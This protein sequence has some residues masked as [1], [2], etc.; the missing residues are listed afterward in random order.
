M[1][2]SAKV[3]LG[4]SIG[5][6]ALTLILLIIYVPLII[7][8]A[9]FQ[10]TFNYE[11]ERRYNDY[12]NDDYYDDDYWDEDYWDEDFLEQFESDRKSG[13]T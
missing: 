3:G 13:N 1:N 7:Y 12:Y 2:S 5:A 10:D 8:S 11:F 4:L 9:E 6:A